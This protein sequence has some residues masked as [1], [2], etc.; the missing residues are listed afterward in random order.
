MPANSLKRTPQSGGR[1]LLLAVSL[2]LARR[3]GRFTR[4]R[5]IRLSLTGI[6]PSADGY[7]LSEHL[8]QRRP[9]HRDVLRPH[10]LQ[11]PS[12]TRVKFGSSHEDRKD[13]GR[14]VQGA[15][16]A[17]EALFALARYFHSRWNPLP[18]GA[19]S[20]FLARR[21]P[22]KTISINAGHPRLRAL[23]DSIIE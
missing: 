5:W 19:V 4:S 1:C 12:V 14:P 18:G 8:M 13:D 15:A 7:R 16:V 11:A 3:P 10:F 23:I 22:L 9:A 21:R 6:Q 17:C 2:S 20:V